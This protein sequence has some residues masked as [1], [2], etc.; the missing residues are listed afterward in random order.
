MGIVDANMSKRKQIDAVE[1]YK[2]VIS[3]LTSG[4]E[5]YSETSAAKYVI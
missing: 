1:K 5:S 3:S 2:D 4:M